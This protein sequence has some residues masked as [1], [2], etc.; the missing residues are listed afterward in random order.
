MT[1]QCIKGG[2]NYHSFGIFPN[3]SVLGRIHVHSS[4]EKRRHLRDAKGVDRVLVHQVV[5]TS[6]GSPKGR[7]GAVA[8]MDLDT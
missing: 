2:K 6:V 5:E 8:K 7:E 1:R 4:V 3:Q